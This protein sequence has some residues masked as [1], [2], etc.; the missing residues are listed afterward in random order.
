MNRNQ[1]ADYIMVQ[2]K[3]KMKMEDRDD[4]HISLDIEE[5]NSDEYGLGF[6]FNNG[7]I[8]TESKDNGRVWQV[9]TYGTGR[10]KQIYE[11]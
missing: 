8:I 3:K 5:A 2:F 4:L 11:M 10:I 7:A 1:I 6:M 9:T